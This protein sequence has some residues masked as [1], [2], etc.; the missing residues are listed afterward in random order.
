M[1]ENKRK[2][3]EICYDMMQKYVEG[4][5]ALLSTNSRLQVILQEKG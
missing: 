2:N 3:K 1:K 5:I 4:S